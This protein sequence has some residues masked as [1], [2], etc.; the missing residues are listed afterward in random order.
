MFD[1]IDADSSGG[2]TAVEMKVLKPAECCMKNDGF[3]I[4]KMLNLHSK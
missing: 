2:I 4:Y 1:K 3:C